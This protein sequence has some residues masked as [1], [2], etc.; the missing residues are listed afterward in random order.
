MKL[1][2]T[3]FESG[4][5]YSLLIDDNGV[6]NWYPTLFATSK[7]RNSAKASNTIEAYLNAVKLLLEWCHTN[8]ILLEETFLKK[9]FLT[10]EQIEADGGC[11]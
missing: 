8:N 2:R 6:P 4:E 11:H 7:L 5:R 10:T 9:Q 1:I 3:K